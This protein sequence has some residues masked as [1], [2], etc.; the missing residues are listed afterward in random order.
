MYVEAKNRK[1]GKTIIAKPRG[2]GT[3]ELKKKIRIP[4]KG[5]NKVA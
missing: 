2:R 3:I 5:S 4:R 1:T